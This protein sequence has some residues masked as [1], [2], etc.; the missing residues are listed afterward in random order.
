MY[1]RL[2]SYL[3]RETEYLPLY[4]G[5]SALA[6]IE[7]VLKRSSEY[8]AF[9]KFIRRLLNNVYQKGGLALK[10]IVDGDDLN[11]VKLQVGGELPA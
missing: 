7:N 4:T 10:R 5:L 6:K 2:A 3:K 9:Q 11:S 1:S 8:G